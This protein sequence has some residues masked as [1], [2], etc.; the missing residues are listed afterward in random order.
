V[1]DQFSFGG[2]LRMS[3]YRTGQFYGDSLAFARLVYYRKL[4]KAVLTEGVYAGV[5]L[6]A[7]RIGGPLVPGSPN[8]VQTSGALILAADTPL[9]PM[10]IGY[11]MG[12]D[13]NRT[14]YFFLGRP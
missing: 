9:G 8:D 14:F 1:Y 3:G 11:G 5:S 7:G 10:Y 4:S 12:E 2:F 13:K 6:E